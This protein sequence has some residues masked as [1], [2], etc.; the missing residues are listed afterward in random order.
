M[1]ARWEFVGLCYTLLN[2]APDMLYRFYGEKN[3]PYVHG[4]LDSNGK[5]ADEVYG[6]KEIHRKVMSQNFTSR[7]TKIHHVHAH[8]TLNDSG[9]VQ[10]LDYS[11]I[12]TRL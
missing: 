9:M 10:V 4:R 5:P 8:A 11:L 1:L 2:Q 3:S 12:T 7:H 6:Q